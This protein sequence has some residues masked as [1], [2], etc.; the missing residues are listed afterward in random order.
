MIM[1][2]VRQAI[3][4]GAKTIYCNNGTE[5]YMPDVGKNLDYYDP[6]SAPKF[7]DGKKVYRKIFCTIKNAKCGMDQIK[8]RCMYIS[9][10]EW[11]YF[12]END[13]CIPERELN[14]FINDNGGIDTY[15]TDYWGHGWMYY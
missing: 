7:I 3:E 5:I 13:Y 2:T 8:C 9:G 11:N 14:M 6:I 15:R 12:H 10:A 4:Q 1:N